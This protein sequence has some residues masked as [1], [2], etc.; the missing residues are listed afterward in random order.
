MHIK[1]NNGF[2]DC[3]IYLIGTAHVSEDSVNKV[4]QAILEIDPDLIAIELDSE[5]F[6]ALLNERD[7]NHSKKNIDVLKIIKE[8][9]IGLFLIHSILSNFQRD[10]GEKF[11]I[12]PGSEM[13]KAVELAKTYK[14]PLSL[15]DRPINIT[16]KRALDSMSL[17]EKLTLLY[18]LLDD[19][20]T[21]KLD[22]E[23]LN[24]M[25][26]NA[27]KLIDLLGELSPSLYRVLVDERDKY[28]AKN[29]FD[30]TSGRERILVV[31]G[32]GH[33]RGIVNYLKKLEKNEIDININELMTLKKK[34]NYFKMAFSILLI[35]IVLYG[36]YSISSNPEALKKLTMEWILING[37]LSALGVILARGKFPSIIAAFLAAPITSLIPI[38]GAGYVVGAVELKYRKITS[39]DISQF[40]KTEDLK[41]LM[42]NNLM[43]V[44]M[45]MA[46]SSIGSAIGTFY[47]I[48]RFL[49]V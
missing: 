26:D 4:E 23:S 7:K 21:V 16:L 47:F 2:N 9:N 33:V 32:A 25:V 48:P 42:N 18:E 46:L 39:E 44:L 12:K 30:I 11:N 3:D 43:R 41:V 17:K 14:K 8:G 28:M 38:I 36:I 27:E 19:K 6:F 37:G 31:V 34:K 35:G 49:G 20:D 29:I 13:K 10:I 45:V 40:L 24:K 5:R 15:I 22:K 1:I